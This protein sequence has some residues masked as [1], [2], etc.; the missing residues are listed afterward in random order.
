[1][2]S[3]YQGKKQKQVSTFYYGL[4]SHMHHRCQHCTGRFVGPDSG[5]DRTYRSWPNNTLMIHTNDLK[6]GDK[7]YYQKEIGHPRKVGIVNWLM[8]NESFGMTIYFENGDRIKSKYIFED[9]FE[10]VEE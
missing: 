6:K 2:Q 4:Q 7:I 10:V 5:D 3:I 1:M 9:A 8:G